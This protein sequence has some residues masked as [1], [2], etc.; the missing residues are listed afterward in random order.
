MK[1]VEILWW[2]AKFDAGGGQG[3]RW[4]LAVAV[5]T[6]GQ[7]GPTVPFRKARG[8]PGRPRELVLTAANR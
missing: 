1:Q 4:E 7:S 3:W 2:I 5:L 8:S 6:E